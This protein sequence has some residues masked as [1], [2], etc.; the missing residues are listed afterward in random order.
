MRTN[1]ELHLSFS[2]ID[3]YNCPFRYKMLYIDKAIK[4]ES[5]FMTT[6]K[7]I[8]ECIKLYSKECI[9]HKVESDF[10]L[11]EECIK[12]I[13]ENEKLNDEQTI[14]IRQALLEICRKKY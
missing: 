9:T 6:G 12:N 11:M 10:Q 5:I 2:Q 14:E 13:F 1:S 7:L 8:H 3:T 4:R